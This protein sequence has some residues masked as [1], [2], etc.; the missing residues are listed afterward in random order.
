MCGYARTTN[1][2]LSSYGPGESAKLGPLPFT[3]D[4]DRVYSVIERDNL[5]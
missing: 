5:T 3:L 2:Q 4:V 1:W